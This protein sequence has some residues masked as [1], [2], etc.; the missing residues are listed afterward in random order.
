MVSIT[1]S[2]HHNI[3][4]S[5]HHHITTSQHHHITTSPHKKKEMT[6]KF[7]K[8]KHW[9]LFVLMFPIPFVLQ[10]IGMAHFFDFFQTFETMEMSGDISPS[11][12]IESMADFAGMMMIAAALVSIFMFGWLWSV[13]VGLQD[14]IPQDLKMKTGLFKGALIL[15]MVYFAGLF[16]VV[17]FVFLNA[18]SLVNMDFSEE[19]FFRIFPTVLSLHLLSI[20]AIIYVLVFAAKTIKIAELQRK[21]KSD[22][23]IGEF[24][25]ICIFIICVWFL[26]PKINEIYEYEAEDHEI[27]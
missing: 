2:Q 15:P 23:F 24:F 6:S 20:A 11:M 16:G 14:K 18:E 25:M 21:I 17:S 27:Y 12:M 4:T 7:L 19:L 5:P 9:Q 26:Q 8:A 22:E 3:T 10:R 1:T 13:G